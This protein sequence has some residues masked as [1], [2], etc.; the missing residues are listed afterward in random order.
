MEM[1]PNMTTEKQEDPMLGNDKE[2][3]LKKLKIW[4]IIFYISLPL[5]VASGVI[6]GLTGVDRKIFP[7]SSVAVLAVF[8]LNLRNP[9]IP[10]GLENSLS[11]KEKPMPMGAFFTIIFGLCLVSYLVTALIVK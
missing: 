1:T 2:K 4:R 8:I 7:L 10:K 9:R 6:V 11:E 3:Y 5:V